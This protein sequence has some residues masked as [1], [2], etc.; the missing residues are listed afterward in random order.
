MARVKMWSPLMRAAQTNAS[1]PAGGVL[2][3]TNPASHSLR[4]ASA[5]RQ[6]ALLAITRR[7]S[8]RFAS[9]TVSSSMSLGAP[10][11]STG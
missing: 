7:R 3:V 8:T 9:L 11:P 10:G 4:T 2:R 5:D 1:A 6:A